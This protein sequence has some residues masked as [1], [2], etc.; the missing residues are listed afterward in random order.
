MLKFLFLC[1]CLFPFNFL[2]LLSVLGENWTII[3][4]VLKL[5]IRTPIYYIPNILSISPFLWWPRV[6]YVTNT[7][8]IPCEIV[9]A[10]R[11]FFSFW[12]KN[13][14]CK[15]SLFPLC[16]QL[17]LLEQNGINRYSRHNNNNNNSYLR[18]K[19]SSKF[20]KQLIF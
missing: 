15:S 18:I 12:A 19:E 9:F 4:S 20:W 17:C 16:L 1:F 3:K 7:Q 5:I 10:L 13:L 11:M 6:Y 14:P 2:E 8:S